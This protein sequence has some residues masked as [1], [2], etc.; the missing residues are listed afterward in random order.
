MHKSVVYKLER[1][2]RKDFPELVKNN[3][4]RR[5]FFIQSGNVR[6][7]SQML[8]QC[9][10]EVLN[11]LHFGYFNTVVVDGW[12]IVDPSPLGVKVHHMRLLYV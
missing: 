8:V 6:V 10:T 1:L 12:D 11:S 3:R 9:Q 5:H 2:T 7:P 4:H